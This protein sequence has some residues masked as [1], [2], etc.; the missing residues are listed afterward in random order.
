MY[1]LK[2]FLETGKNEIIYHMVVEKGK[3][4]NFV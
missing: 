2:R 1:T 4:S 3:F